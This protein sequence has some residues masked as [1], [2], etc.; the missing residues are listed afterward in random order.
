MT[1]K[2]RSVEKIAKKATAWLMNPVE[3]DHTD[4]MG[5]VKARY[6][7]AE[8]MEKI[9]TEAL[10][11]ERS[12]R[13]AVEKELALEIKC[14]ETLGA[15]VRQRDRRLASHKLAIQKAYESIKQVVQDNVHPLL[16]NGDCP[17]GCGNFDDC[18]CAK[19]ILEESLTTL[20]ELL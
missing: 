12:Q 4:L 3:I 17:R 20:K 9:M 15:T 5:E 14:S 7:Q 18:Y 6:K 11:L 19:D 1:D 13:E 16:P 10:S 8:D 2:L